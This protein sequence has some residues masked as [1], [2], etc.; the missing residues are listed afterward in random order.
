M[1]TPRSFFSRLT[2]QGMHVAGGRAG[3]AAA[4]ARLT[5]GFLDSELGRRAAAASERSCELP[6]LH[7]WEGPGGPLTISGRVDLFFR[8]AEGACLVD[9]K[10]DKILRPAEHAAHAVQ[11]G[12]YRLAF[13]ELV[14]GAPLDAC[15]FLLRGPALLRYGPEDSPPWAELLPRVLETLNSSCCPSGDPWRLPVSTSPA[16]EGS[17]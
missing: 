7:L 11:L 5:R 12:L 3:L 16:A 13:S 10:T 14:A 1:S 6:F 8:D 4:A 15:L 2:S 9:Y 17:V